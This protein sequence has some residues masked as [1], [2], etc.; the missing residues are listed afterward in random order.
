MTLG[1]LVDAGLEVEDLRRELAKL[2]LDGYTLQSKKIK[3]KGIAGTK[4]DF[5]VDEVDH[6]H[7]NLGVI[8]EII[9]NSSL[10][11]RVKDL[12]KKVFGLLAAAEAKVHGVGIAEVHFHEVGAL[13]SIL[14]IVGSLAGL[15]LLGV[16]RV[17]S[18]PVPLGRGTVM[19]AHG[20]L[21]VPAPATA[22]LLKGIPSRSLDVEGE[23]TT[24]TG[25][26]ILS[27][28]S[29]SFGVMP[30]LKVEGVGYGGGSKDFPN[31]PNLLRVF[32]GEFSE[33]EGPGL[34]EYERDTVKL[35]EANI[36][37]L[38]PEVYDYLIDSLFEHGA[39]DVYLTPISMKKS[40]PATKLS[41]LTT[42]E[43]LGELAQIIFRETTTIGL[44]LKEME[45]I[46]LPRQ[47]EEI[48]T[49]F[50]RVRVKVSTTKNVSTVKPEY[51]DCKK[52]A[53]ARGIPLRHVYY[54]VVKSYHAQREH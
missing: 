9:D 23:V 14:D 46:K 35:I 28:L 11:H 25:A 34:D 41:V 50:G 24:P 17:F 43:L 48:E 16:E 51:E 31:L 19:T 10:S 32:I 6:P 7:R 42:P 47:M 33:V 3:K 21:P 26:A 18:S 5:L 39:L 13:D 45:R 8:E 36:D 40:R 27:A 53:Q 20:L 15:D 22:E 30:D 1:A 49:G 54:E 12:S 38:S 37:D 44:R 52:I 29:S 2:G 4:I